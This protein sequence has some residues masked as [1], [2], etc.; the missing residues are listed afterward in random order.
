MASKLLELAR[1]RFGTLENGERKLSG[2]EVTLFEA[3]VKGQ[4]ARYPAAAGEDDDP[5]NAGKWGKPRI[6]KADRIE[7]LCTDPEASKLVTH[8]GI[9]I[10][11]ARIDGAID[12]EF[13]MIPFP[14]SFTHAAVPGGIT[15]TYAKIN[16]VDLSGTHTGSINAGGVKVEGDVFLR[17]GFK[18]EGEVCL[19][20]AT[21]GGSLACDA[22]QFVNKAES[23][24]AINADGIK[25][26]GS[27]FLRRGFKAEGEVH[28]VGATIGGNIECDGG[29]FVNK[30]GGGSAISAD[31]INVEGSVFLREGFKAEGEV[32]LL[33][34]KIGGDLDCEG[35]QFADKTEGEQ[36][37]NADRL[38]VE[39]SVFLRDGFKAE[40][41]VCLLGSTIGGNLECDGGQFVN[42]VDGRRAIS[43]QGIKVEHVF[44]RDGFMAEGKVDLVGATVNGCLVWTKVLSPEKAILDL[45]AAKIGTLQD[46]VDS[47]PLKGKLF[48]YGMVYGS[49]DDDAPR[50]ATPRMDWLHRQAKE[51][52]LSQ[53][54]EQLASVLRL[55]GQEAD[56]RKV[57]IAKEKDRADVL[58]KTGAGVVERLKRPARV[59]WWWYR[60]LGPI[61]GYGYALRGAFGRSLAVIVTG[62]LMF[63]L[64]YQAEQMTPPGESAYVT[65]PANGVRTLSERYPKFNAAVYSLDM[66]LPI[67]NLY[68]AD[69][70]LPNANAGP[71]VFHLWGVVVRTGGLLRVYLWFHILSGWTLT[72]LLVVGLTR[73]IRS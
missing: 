61:I 73:T 56:A 45:R 14:I 52:F 19:L 40:G 69:F 5:A 18:A 59:D 22:G 44:L 42:K 3:V 23:G 46:D 17:Q 25:V 49:I 72:T 39:G 35:G 48:L 66:F 70:W 62:W 27:V 51:P 20:W 63:W 43:A 38:K 58:F 7:W 41:E 10:E 54:Y 64:G 32:R 30:V 6:L 50:E 71:E 26:E 67:I 8:R 9:W 47:W 16:S 29:Q 53:P 28:L 55:S 15:L 34:A 21:I 65:D 24:K 31:R 13:A 57:L 33:G 2:S 11:G 68:Q 60:A 37:I 36:A 12:L 1:E 4:P